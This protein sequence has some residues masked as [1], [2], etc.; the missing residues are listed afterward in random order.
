MDWIRENKTL[1]SIMGVFLA[2]AAALG[3]LVI[4]SWS[5]FGASN[6]RF[7]AANNALATMKSANLYPSPE[8]LEKKK[9][10][11]EDYEKKVTTLS[12]VLLSLQPAVEPISETDFQAKLKAKIAEV[13]SIS[14]KPT[15]LPSESSLGFADYTSSLPKSAA[16]AQELSEYVDAT[17][18]VVRVFIDSGVESVDTFERSLLASEKGETA[19]PPSAPAAPPKAGKVGVAGKGKAPVAA[20]AVAEMVERRTLTFTLTCDQGPLQ[21]V[22][23]RLAS[24]SEMPYFAAVRLLR[25]ENEKNEGPLRAA[26]TLELSKSKSAAV[27]AAAAEVP[28]E[29]VVIGTDGLPVAA[30]E[31]T[32]KA[33]GPAKPGIKDA[34]GVMGQE[35]LK[36]YMEIDLIKFIDPSKQ[37]A[38]A[39]N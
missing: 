39:A 3:F 30:A 8:N 35:K 31:A 36:V 12:K 20:K 16:I 17:E 18:A 6:D 13:R 25:V 19:A 33:T 2:L 29:Q 28:Q 27:D 26:V 14:G 15:K 10:A 1:A 7:I 32:L 9:S 11:V 21:K 5:S 24:P 37:V 23:N 22:L 34:V 38:G 4:N